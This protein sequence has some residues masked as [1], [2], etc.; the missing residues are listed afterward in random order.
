M[1]LDQIVAAAT[2]AKSN[3]AERFCMGAAWRTP[4]DSDIEQVSEAIAAVK[5]SRFEPALNAFG[6][7]LP[8]TI[9]VP[10]NFGYASER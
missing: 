1:P 4:K 10:L 6:K 7:P 8:Y 3:G 9:T 5:G 2:E